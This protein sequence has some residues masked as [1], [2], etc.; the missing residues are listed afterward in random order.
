M[1]I[2]VYMSTF[3]YFWYGTWICGPKR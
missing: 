3:F 1:F 2:L